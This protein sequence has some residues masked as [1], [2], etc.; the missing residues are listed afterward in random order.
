MGRMLL[1]LICIALLIGLPLSA[2]VDPPDPTWIA[3]M[4][5]DGD[6]DDA[7]ATITGTMAIVDMRPIVRI[8]IAP[9]P[10]LRVVPLTP[11]VA[12]P[13]VHASFGSRAPPAL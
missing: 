6:F 2:N 8:V 13:V 7:I 1:G 3:G 10:V 4:Y 5:D 12:D 9:D 11:G